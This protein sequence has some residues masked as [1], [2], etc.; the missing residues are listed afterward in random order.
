ME[1]ALCDSL[2]AA[3]IFPASESILKP[4]VHDHI[5]QSSCLACRHHLTGQSSCLVCRHHLTGEP[6][7][8]L[9]GR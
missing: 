2:Y 4:A 8:A 3:C 9:V 6:K 5:D 1:D 7:K